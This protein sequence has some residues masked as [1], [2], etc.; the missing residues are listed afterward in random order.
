MT[1]PLDGWL[2]PGTKRVLA[3][4]VNKD[5]QVIVELGSWLGL[6]ALYLAGLAP[7]ARIYCIDHWKGSEEHQS[8]PRLDSLYGSFKSHT[9]VH[10]ARIVAV[11]DSTVS[12]MEALAA[13]GVKPDVVYVD[14]DHSYEGCLADIKAIRR[15][16]PDAVIVG[17]DWHW[18]GV[19]RAA[20]EVA[21][22]EGLG[23][24][25]DGNGWTFGPKWTAFPVRALNF[26]SRRLSGATA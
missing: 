26:L 6:S 10:G 24:H 19:R 25:A 17:D 8:D 20:Q 21:K 15:L 1:V 23:V 4:A 5:T 18:Q 13:Q 3:N 16:W 12:G 2:A 7:K 22:A 11:R 14:A 9:Q